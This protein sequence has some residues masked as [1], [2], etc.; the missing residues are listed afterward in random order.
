V[1][2]VAGDACQALVVGY[3]S[4]ARVVGED[5]IEVGRYRLTPG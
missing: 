4:A 5:F 3:S 1:Y 2:D